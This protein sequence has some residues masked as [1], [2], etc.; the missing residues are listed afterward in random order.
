MQITI[1]AFNSFL[2]IFFNPKPLVH[3]THLL[4]FSKN[5]I[6]KVKRAFE[7]EVSYGK[8]LISFSCVSYFLDKKS[9]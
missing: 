9:F 3:L 2:S 8:I 1:A 5:G 7:L 4:P 6:P